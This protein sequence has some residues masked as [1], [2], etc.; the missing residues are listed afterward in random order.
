MELIKYTVPIRY[1]QIDK[2]NVHFHCICQ[3]KSTEWRM[4][5]KITNTSRKHNNNYN[6]HDVRYRIL[7]DSSA[8][9]KHIH[10][11]KAIL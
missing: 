11:Q 5:K 4:K 3:C 8:L 10:E 7:A 9:C 2:R 1:Q 6:A